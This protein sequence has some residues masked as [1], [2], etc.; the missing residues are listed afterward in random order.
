MLFFKSNNLRIQKPVYNFIAY[1]P[2]NSLKYSD[3]FK[4]KFFT[5]KQ[6]NLVLVSLV[7]F[8]VSSFNSH[9]HSDRQQQTSDIWKMLDWNMHRHRYI[10]QM[11]WISNVKTKIYSITNFW[12][13]S[14]SYPA[15]QWPQNTKTQSDAIEISRQKIHWTFKEYKTP[16]TENARY[17]TTTKINN[18][19]KQDQFKFGVL[20]V[21]CVYL[22]L[23]CFITE[24]FRRITNKSTSNRKTKSFVCFWFA[25]NF[26]IINSD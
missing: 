9:W 22:Y 24:P 17:T 5:E 10:T 18:K 20:L 7:F 12:M 21:L 1:A 6:C 14:C 26:S 16:H 4:N 13:F 3:E 19:P 2:K 23:M 15:K 11:D 25:L 8:F